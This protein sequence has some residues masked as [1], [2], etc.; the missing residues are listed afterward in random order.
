MN[1]LIYVG[2]F[3]IFQFLIMYVFS[4]L[5]GGKGFRVKGVTAVWFCGGT[6]LTWIWICWKFIR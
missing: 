5:G 2:G 3:P 6:L 1:W 4:I